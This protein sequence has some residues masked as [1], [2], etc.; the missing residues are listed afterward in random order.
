MKLELALRRILA[1]EVKL[2]RKKMPAP[3]VL[4]L[5]LHTVQSVAPQD[6]ALTGLPVEIPPVPEWPL[7]MGLTL[8]YFDREK[9][10]QLVADTQPTAEVPHPVVPELALRG[11]GLQPKFAIESLHMRE[12]QR[13]LAP[14]LAH[15]EA[16]H[17]MVQ[18][19]PHRGPETS[20]VLAAEQEPVLEPAPV[21]HLGQWWKLVGR[22]PAVQHPTAPDLAQQGKWLELAG[23]MRELKL[24]HPME[25]PAWPE[26]D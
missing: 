4:V 8:A 22:W 18:T 9:Q 21:A 5:Q 7:P 3:S 17:P 2:R 15:H 26:A 14:V 23:Q 10:P 25:H 11:P 12:L 19:L 16:K 6:Y 24:P 20:L 1:A 13:L